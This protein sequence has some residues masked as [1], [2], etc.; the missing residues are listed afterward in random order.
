MF[1]NAV[2]IILFVAFSASV[3][4]QS[5]TD[6]RRFDFRN[7]TIHVG[8]SDTNELQALYN[9]PRGL[10]LT[11]YL[12]DGVGLTYDFPQSNPKAPDWRAELTTDREAHPEPKLWIRVIE[13]VDDH[14]TG[15]GTW[16]YV[17]AFSCE[18]GHLIRKFQFS[19][20]GVFL[21]HLDDK[22]LQLGQ[23]I[24]VPSDSH[25]DPSHRRTLT[26]KWNVRLHQYSLS[27][28]TRQADAKPAN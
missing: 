9:A 10:A 6:I 3:R 28:E 24:W 15:T 26:F 13:L 11:F 27:S 22:T 25:A 23:G 19:A 5:C 1:R 14:L 18:N 12:R 8:E 4:S 17:L 2:G 20:E 7:S 21:E 16:R